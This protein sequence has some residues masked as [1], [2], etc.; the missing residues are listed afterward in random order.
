MWLLDYNIIKNHIN[1]CKKNNPKHFCND[2]PSYNITNCEYFGSTVYHLYAKSGT[3][4]CR[5]KMCE[6]IFGGENNE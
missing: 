5:L 6:D 3:Q 1:Y 4:P 2:C